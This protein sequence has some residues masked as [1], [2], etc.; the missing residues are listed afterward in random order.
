M[1]RFMYGSDMG[2]IL[3][4]SEWNSLFS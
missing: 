3:R 1:G 4:S 2:R